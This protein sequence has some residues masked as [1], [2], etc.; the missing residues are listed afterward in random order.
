MNLKLSE[1]LR[2]RNKVE[3]L[4][5][6]WKIIPEWI[7]GKKGEEMWTGCIWLKLSGLHKRWGIS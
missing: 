1:N 6:N 2:G 4:S 5:T 3:D 7:L